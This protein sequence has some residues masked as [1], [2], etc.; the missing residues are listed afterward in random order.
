MTKY[1]FLITLIVFYTY[2]ALQSAELSKSNF[3]NGYAK[4]LK[5]K[6][7][8]VI[9][10]YTDW[11]HWC[12]VM[13]KKTFND[14]EIKKQLNDEFVFIQLNPDNSKETVSFL[15]DQGE[16]KGSVNEFTQALRVTGYPSMVFMDKTGKV[17]TVIP[18]Y[19]P[20]ETFAPLLNYMKSECYSKKVNL[21]DYLDKKAD[22]N[23]N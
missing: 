22:C 12:K 10:L 2:S 4:A 11:C 5:E 6:K 17:V 15:H 9:D 8:I 19:I 23:T 21:Q 18:G 1:F 3:K 16:F 7:P 20:K 13:E 14:P